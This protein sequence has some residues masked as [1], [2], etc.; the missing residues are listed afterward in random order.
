[1]R[2]EFVLP[3]AEK[4][5][6]GG[7]KIVYEY[8][9]RLTVRGHNISIMYINERAFESYRLPRKLRKVMANL[10]TRVE[11]RWYDLNK[12]I[13]KYSGLDSRKNDKRAKV[14][15]VFCTAVDTVKYVENNYDNNIKKF[16]FIQG[17][18]NWS[19]CTCNLSSNSSKCENDR[20]H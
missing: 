4:R 3:K 10:L 18:E 9:N 6:V 1:M 16:Y 12:K 20:T 8:A 19:V 7:Y 14:D 5:I 17:Y 13:K 15:V 11:P 2:I